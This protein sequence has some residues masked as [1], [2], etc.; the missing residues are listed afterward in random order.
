VTLLS[1]AIKNNGINMPDD[2]LTTDEFINAFTA[3]IKQKRK[4]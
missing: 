4:L 3:N 1:K 2:I